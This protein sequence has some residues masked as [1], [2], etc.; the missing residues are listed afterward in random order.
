M[1]LSD[2]QAKTL[3]EIL[4]AQSGAARM[5]DKE[6]YKAKLAE[7]AQF[8]NVDKANKPS[9]GIKNEV[10]NDNKDN[11]ELVD[12]AKAH[13]A[14]AKARADKAVAPKKP[15]KAKAEKAPAKPKMRTPE[16]EKE[17]AAAIVAYMMAVTGQ[18]RIEKDGKNDPEGF[19]HVANKSRK[20]VD[21]KKGG[22][23]NTAPEGKKTPWERFKGF[24]GVTEACKAHQAH[25]KAKAKDEPAMS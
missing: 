3:V 8:L 17:T 15:A 6:A 9:G 5:E 23:L 25:V 11:K 12:A 19:R 7:V 16:E 24:P 10:Y 4:N 2:K 20:Y 14:K 21:H 18:K 1:K 13:I 22:L